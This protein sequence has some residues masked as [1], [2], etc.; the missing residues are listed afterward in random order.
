[1]PLLLL[2]G[3]LN[4]PVAATSKLAAGAYQL[5]TVLFDA[6][7]ATVKLKQIAMMSNDERA[8]HQTLT[9]DGWST[10]IMESIYSWNVAFPSRRVILLKA[11]NLSEISHTG[12][13]LSGEV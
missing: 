7:V 6:A 9:M 2:P 5:C 1:M 3:A 11:D 8:Y 4:P 13:V 12:E 10:R